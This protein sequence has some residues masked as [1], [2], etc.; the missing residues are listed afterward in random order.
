[1]A[2]VYPIEFDGGSTLRRVITWKQSDN[3][4]PVDL[5]GYTA[6]MHVRPS[7]ESTEVLLTCTTENGRITLGGAA[8]TVTLLVDAETTADLA[9]TSAKYDLELV[10]ADATPVVTRLIEGKFKAKLE[11]TR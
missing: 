10:S 5:T 4:T 6:R 11:V 1:M 9:G 3:V 2:G 8:G 7:V